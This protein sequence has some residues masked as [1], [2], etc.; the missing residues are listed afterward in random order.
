MVEFTSS[1]TNP[2][3]ESIFT[4]PHIIKKLNSFNPR[5]KK[6]FKLIQEKL[7]KNGIHILY[8]NEDSNL[9]TNLAI[10]HRN[11]QI[12]PNIEDDVSKMIK[13]FRKKYHSSVHKESC[14]RNI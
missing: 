14:E 6:I 13:Q 8:K 11:I 7:K 5:D 10:R 1:Y 12:K 4:N 3:S 9:H 2:G